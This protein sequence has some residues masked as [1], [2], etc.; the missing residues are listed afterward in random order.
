MTY[1]S[2][3]EAEADRAQQKLML[4]VLNAWDR[5]LR[6]DECGAWC[7]SG[8]CGTLHT[9]GDGKSW[10]LYVSCNSGQ[11]W[12]W[13]KKKLSFCT[14]TQD[15]D[16]EGVLRLDQLPT[17]DQANIIRHVLGI[18]KRREVSADVLRR[19]KTFAFDR[20]PRSTASVDPDNGGSTF[21]QPNPV[22]DQM[23][24]LNATPSSR[25]IA[26]QTLAG[27]VRDRRR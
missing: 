16:E 21:G 7:I 27:E 9:W 26:A 17:P 6:R 14:V 1:P 25:C 10:A 8:T 15:G 22:P 18:Q 19:L 5:A 20:K 11:H 4:A 24:I 23:P 2:A 3:A 13:V 12:T